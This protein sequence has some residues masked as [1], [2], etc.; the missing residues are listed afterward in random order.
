VS[1]ERRICVV[2]NASTGFDVY[3]IDS[4][5][6]VHTLSTGVPKRTYLKRVAFVSKGHAV[7]GGSDHGKVYIFDRRTGKVITTLR[8][9]KDGGVET[10]AVSGQICEGGPSNS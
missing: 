10:I 4:S 9:A 5:L 7:V 3:K 8:H 6:F 1:L 2:N